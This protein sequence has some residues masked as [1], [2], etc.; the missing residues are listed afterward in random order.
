M[1]NRYPTS[2]DALASSSDLST[3]MHVDYKYYHSDWVAIRDCIAGERRIKEKNT[4]Y[5]PALDIEY[6]TTYEQYKQRAVYTNMVS[7]TVSGLVGTIFRRPLKAVNV[8]KSLIK[9]VT[10]SGLSLNLFAKKLAYEVC[11][12]GRVGVLVDMADNGQAYLTEYVAE[13]ILSWRTKIVNGKEVLTYVLLREIV[14]ESPILDGT[15]HVSSTYSL[16]GLKARYRVL[17]LDNGVY[18]QRVYAVAQSNGVNPAFASDD[19]TEVTPTRNGTPFDFIP[20][21][22]L[23]PLSPTPEIQKSP[24]YDIMS[25]NL[26]HYRTSAQLEHGRYYTALPVYYVPTAPGA[27]A[28]DYHVGPSVVWEVSGDGKPGILEY[29]GT[30]LKSLTDSMIEKEEHIAQLGGRIMGIRPQAV[31]ESDNIFQMKQA[32]EMSILLNIT[33]SMS[34]GLTKAFIWYLEWMRKPAKNVEIKLNQD[35]KALQLAARELRA[36]ALLYQ[37]GILPVQAVFNALQAGEF[38]P[39]EWTLEDFVKLLGDEDNFPNQ[40]NVPAKMEGYPDAKTKVADEQKR[41]AENLQRSEGAKDR[42]HEADLEEQMFEQSKQTAKFEHELAKDNPA[43]K[44]PVKSS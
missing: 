8:D 42:E 7:R 37:E 24:I 41:R 34:E 40:P 44:P 3:Y 5:L 6:G 2:Q 30:G 22:I 17:I 20:M 27:E 1:V 9:S 26:A 15:S 16:G 18:K 28:A 38:I 43:A 33:E 13:N 39:E 11:A 21:V 25:L 31:A 10:Q 14:D 32:N 12:V 35:F 4:Q 19:Y 36:F 29:Y 23:G